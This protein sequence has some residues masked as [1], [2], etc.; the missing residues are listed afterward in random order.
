MPQ[1]RLPLAQVSM[2]AF[3]PTRTSL[4]DPAGR[5]CER[6]QIAENV[7]LSPFLSGSRVL[8]LCR[9][10]QEWHAVS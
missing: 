8:T 5:K 1:R 3:M 4:A 10:L 6:V 2:R 7:R 9:G